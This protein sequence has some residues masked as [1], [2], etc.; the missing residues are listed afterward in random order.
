M[1]YTTL[2]R[3]T[4]P[5][6]FL[7][8]KQSDLTQALIL[9][10]CF[11]STQS[12][13]DSIDP[14]VTLQREQAVMIAR[15]GQLNEAIQHLQQLHVQHPSDVRVVADLV[16]L[17]R[18]AGRNSEIP[19]LTQQQTIQNFP[20]YAVMPW[21]A[22]LRDLHLYT[23][24][25]RLLK[26][27]QSKDPHGKFGVK[28]QILYA[29]VSA[30][31]GQ[32]Q[33]ALAALPVVDA[34]LDATDLAQMAYVS[35][36]AKKPA[37]ALSFSQ[38]ARSKDPNHA[39]AIQ[40][41]VYALS[42]L[43]AIDAAYQL[44]S[45]HPTLFP[46]QTI[47]Q[48]RADRT[49]LQLRDA[50]SE[51]ERLDGSRR[52]AVRN[53]PLTDVLA[54]IDE[55]LKIFPPQSAQYRRTQFDRIYVLRLLNRMPETI[56]AYTQLTV[57]ADQIPTYV[58]RAAAD[59]YLADHQP[60]IAA[61]MYT[62]LLK[63]QNDAALS[64]S[65][66]RALIEAED[67]PQAAEVLA[68]LDRETPLYSRHVSSG[69]Q[70]MPNW[71]RLEVDQ[72]V[73]MDA[74]YRN[75]LAEAEAKL[76]DLFN[77]APRNL[78]VIN[79]YAT[80]LRWRGL[81]EHADQITAIAATYEPQDPATRINIANNANELEQIP[82][83]GKTIT[84]LNQDLPS[85]S[86]VQKNYA[87]W[88]DRNRASI[89]SELSFGQ[90]AGTGNIIDVNGNQDLDWETR[91]NTPWIMDNWRGFVQHNRRWSDVG[92]SEIDEQ[93]LGAGAEW[94]SE[95]RNAWVML[96]QQLTSDNRTGVSAGWSQWLNDYW[97]YGIQGATHSDQ[98]PLRALDQGLS[99]KSANVSLKWRQSESR[100]AYL[101]LGLLDIDYGNRRQTIA[102]GG[103]QRL[104][105]G[106]DF[107]TTGGMDFYQES[108]SRMGGSYYNPRNTT[109]AS[110][111]LRH[112][113]MTWREYE[114]S[115]TQSF[116]V[117]T[118]FGREANF[119]NAPMFD[120]LYQHAW[121]F[122]RSWRL[123][124]GVAWGTHTYDGQREGRVSGLLGFDGVF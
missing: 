91:V 95:R 78:G 14:A 4:T 33:E 46:L 113:W 61:Q 9:L 58:Q 72:T 51:R 115:L 63:Q 77:R 36:L 43:S 89:S 16:V 21:I 110:I 19:Q 29:L 28:G 99:A 32:F 75:H 118:G 13:A 1:P 24:A 71:E 116:Q 64:L 10:G 23:D 5:R 37:Q 56:T 62:A 108:N 94:S 8:W 39:L 123:H 98:I 66:Y 44:A 41:S 103:A 45:A 30:E 119:G 67:Y 100:S 87:T 92:L 122:S 15:S 18:Q 96:N 65:L 7:R 31:A 124:Y 12:W 83:W 2:K 49:V 69:G 84:E 59:A 73:A 3:T 107:V 74:A 47:N 22:A 90:S 55:N 54:A 111:R 53:Q 25:L 93:R 106:D 86:G 112:D 120:L 121:Q 6:K 97:Q 27:L 38:L 20:Q 102:L 85:D 76:E 114:R 117:S 57:P 70:R 48:L 42:N 35:R 26:E 34:T 105:E 68:K 11:S 81:P 17:L 88:R 80:V 60:K 101:K 109:S 40:E 50:V 82:R 79:D 52:F 104:L